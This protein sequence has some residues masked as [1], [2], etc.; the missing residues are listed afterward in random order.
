MF[1]DTP[2]VSSKDTPECL[3]IGKEAPTILVTGAEGQSNVEDHC[4]SYPLLQGWKVASRLIH[5]QSVRNPV[6]KA[7]SEKQSQK[8]YWFADC[9]VACLRF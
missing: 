9:P 2:K 4:E 6:V 7:E 1:R 3:L 5:V 8:L